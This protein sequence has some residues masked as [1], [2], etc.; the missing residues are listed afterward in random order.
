VVLTFV[1]SGHVTDAIIASRHR[2]G[3][4]RVMHDGVP[5]A[6]TRIASSFVFADGNKIPSGNNGVGAWLRCA[7]DW[8][9][10]VS[11]TVKLAV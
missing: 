5:D 10:R 7:K 8:L 4:M 2:S 9:R 6:D 1:T 11:G 3:S